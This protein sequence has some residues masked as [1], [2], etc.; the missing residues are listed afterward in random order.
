MQSRVENERKIKVF[1]LVNQW[2]LMYSFCFMEVLSVIENTPSVVWVQIGLTLIFTAILG[3]V[4][5]KILKNLRQMESLPEW[6]RTLCDSFFLPSAWLIWG[7]GVLFSIET[8]VGATS[9]VIS[10]LSIAK[11]RNIFFVTF[12][13][14]ILLRWKFHFQTVL[15]RQMNKRESAAQ[16]QAL[17]RAIG[18]V[19]TI[20]ILAVSGLMILDILDVQLTA[21]LAFGGI[22]GVAIGFAGKDI[23]ANF[24]G[25]VMIHLNRHFSIGEWI[26]SPNKHF[27]GVV[28]DIGWYMTRIR[29]F[30][31]RPTYI[32]NAVFIDA[33]VEN[34]GRMYNRRIKETI[35]LRYEDVKK[36]DPIIQ[37]IRKYLQ[38]H[39]DIDQTKFLFVHFMRF[40][41]HSLDIEVYCFT[42]TTNWGT[43]REVQQGIFLDIAE[44]IASH[45]AE[46]AFPTNT[47]H[48]ESSIPI[49][50]PKNGKD[51]F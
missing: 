3:V 24:F 17:V 11:L 33:I 25:G 19:V 39:P 49:K 31:R 34:P 9:I 38:G 2:L 45:S 26:M 50:C 28:E 4:V 36:V 12:A 21:L 7:Y 41:S 27:E 48:I 13:T 16:D 1:L 47:V 51:H 8:L 6:I 22:G 40:G 43:W 35:G 32:P 42:K 23:V 30:E 10:V 14:W 5:R 29:T 44:I 37:D 20:F 15:S 46:I 18:K